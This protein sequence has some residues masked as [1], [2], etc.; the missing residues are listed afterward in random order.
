MRPIH[1]EILAQ[2]LQRIEPD[3]TIR[4]WARKLSMDSGVLSRILSGR[5]PL[6]IELAQKLVTRL[7]SEGEA[8]VDF[9]E[10]VLED[11]L[12]RAIAAQRRLVKR[13]SDERL[14]EACQKILKRFKQD[15]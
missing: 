4:G 14:D 3:G 15:I 9:L 2:E 1:L 12:L 7:G 10:A 13:T 5:R 8:A 6:S 11:Q